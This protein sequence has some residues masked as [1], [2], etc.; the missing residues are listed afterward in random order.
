MHQKKRSIAVHVCILSTMLFTLHECF[1]LPMKEKEL[2]HIY[3]REIEEGEITLRVLAHLACIDPSFSFSL[4]P[5]T[6]HSRVKLRIHPRTGFL[7]ASFL[8]VIV[9]ISA[10]TGK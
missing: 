7:F 5:C 1:C 6:H 10:A 9:L 3:S 8:Y 4:P 2:L